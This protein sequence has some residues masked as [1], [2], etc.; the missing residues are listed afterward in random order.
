M[1]DNLPYKLVE[2]IRCYNPEV[3]SSYADYPDGGFDLTDKSCE[4]SFWV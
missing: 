4:G 2:G 1:S 3:A